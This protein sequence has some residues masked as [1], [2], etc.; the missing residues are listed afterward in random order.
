MDLKIKDV[1]ELL[2]VSEATVHK[3]LAEEKIPHY[4]IDGSFRFGKQEIE[5]WVMNH[6][7]GTSFSQNEKI[8]SQKYPSTG[9]SQKFS[10]Y[11]AIHKG[12]VLRDV[13]A[14]D[15][16]EIIRQ[17]AKTLSQTHKFDHEVLTELLLDREN[18]Q[19][20]AL[21][22]GIAIPHSRDF[23]LSPTHDMVT[24]VF[25]KEPLEFGA[26]DG[27]PVHTFIFLFACNDKRHLHLLAKIAHLSHQKKT[28]EMFQKRPTKEALLE[29]VHEWESKIPHPQEE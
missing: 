18:L 26:L 9:G 16:E 3:W 14:H 21:N 23:I 24:F 25:P 13:T 5:D 11:R 6:P 1:S 29:F 2:N 22:N 20:T 28:Q 17:S 10:L 12:D 27:N 7:L 4:K 15:K 8:T 19:S